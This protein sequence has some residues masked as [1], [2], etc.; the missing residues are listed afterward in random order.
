MYILIDLQPFK[1]YVCCRFLGP[2]RPIKKILNTNLININNIFLFIF[3]ADM[4]KTVGTG[5]SQPGVPASN[6]GVCQ[7]FSQKAPTQI[8]LLILLFNNFVFWDVVLWR[9]YLHVL[10]TACYKETFYSISFVSCC[11]IYLQSIIFYKITVQCNLLC[12]LYYLL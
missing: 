11:S 4:Y 1:F 6:T 9:H 7:I 5:S 10:L 2:Y 3:M 8:V 12:L